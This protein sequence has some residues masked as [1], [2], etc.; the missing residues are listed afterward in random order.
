MIAI[1]V[2]MVAAAE[3]QREPEW[4]RVL[5]GY[6][7]ENQLSIQDVIRADKPWNFSADVTAEIV[8]GGPFGYVADITY[9]GQY[10][11]SIV[12]PYPPREM[13]CVRLRKG[14]REEILFVNYYSDNLWQHGWVIHR[15]RQSGELLTG[16]GCH[17]NG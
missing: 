9:K 16:V 7:K 17:Q 11:Y 12:L 5:D 8:D 13:Y 1:V 4:Q 15:S 3:A 14:S 6:V 10:T 2:T